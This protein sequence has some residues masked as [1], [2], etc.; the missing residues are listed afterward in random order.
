MDRIRGRVE[1]PRK[2]GRGVGVER[3]TGMTGVWEV[4]FCCELIVGEV[5]TAR[6]V[7]GVGVPR[8]RKRFLAAL[9]FGWVWLGVI[10]RGI[11]IPLPGLFKWFI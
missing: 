6:C 9:V 1:N 2:G 3:V 10:H 11:E 7:R 4:I 5:L 8:S